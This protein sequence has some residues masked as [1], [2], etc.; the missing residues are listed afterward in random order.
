MS[1]VA[2]NL[3]VR[4]I[5]HV[6]GPARQVAQSVKG[7]VSA[8]AGAGGGVARAQAGIARAI[9]ANNAAVDN[10]RG[11]VVDAVGAAYV[12]A[13]AI[14]SPIKSAMAFESAM[15]DVR[16]VVDFPTPAAF[17]AFGEQIKEMSTRLP[18]AVAGLAEI[19]A[20]AGQ[21]GIAQ[22]DILRFTEAAAKIGVAF[23]I[24][25]SESGEALAKM[26]AGL[27]MTIDEVTLL[28]DAMNHLSNAQASSAASILDVVRRVGASGTQIGVQRHPDGRVRVRDDRRRRRQRGRGDVVPQHGHGAGE[29]RE[30]DE[31]PARRLERS[32]P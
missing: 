17:K 4:L 7:I 15:A 27:G 14:S 26:M 30:R 31:A 8:T 6:S 12:L 20:A 18:V 3:I 19:A 24:S 21:A 5:D 25:A 11:R 29:R 16:K 23:D 28:S 32:R 10:M 22:K 1:N 13:N 9:A 2:S